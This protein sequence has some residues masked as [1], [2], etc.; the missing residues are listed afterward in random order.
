M[1]LYIETA[2]Y[3]QYLL[4]TSFTRQLKKLHCCLVGGL[5]NTRNEIEFTT[6]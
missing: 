5:K 6:N 1:N 3:R 2:S 4:M